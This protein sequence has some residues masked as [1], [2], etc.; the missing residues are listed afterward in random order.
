MHKEGSE[1]FMDSITM[2]N[3]CK[4]VSSGSLLQSLW[5]GNH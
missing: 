1:C 3:N 2:I 4:E 5:S